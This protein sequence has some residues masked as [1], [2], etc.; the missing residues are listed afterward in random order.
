MGLCQRGI[1]YV[2]HACAFSYQSWNL[3]N[4][5]IIV[6]SSKMEATI[7][8]V[9]LMVGCST[10][11]DPNHPMCFTDK[12]ADSLPHAD[13]CKF[14]FIFPEKN[15]IIKAQLWKVSKCA[16]FHA[17]AE[18]PQ[19]HYSVFAYF[20]LA[21]FT[22]NLFLRRMTI[23]I[24]RSGFVQIGYKYLCLH[25]PMICLM[26]FEFALSMIIL[27]IRFHDTHTHTLPFKSLESPRKW[28]LR[29]TVNRKYSQ[30]IVSVRNNNF[31]LENVL[32]FFAALHIL[33]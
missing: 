33:H 3:M 21:S 18:P 12:V 6:A 25:E 16:S 26:T 8:L 20:R 31:V 2:T 4:K 32:Y 14:L 24:T 7:D 23:W 1:A 19:L 17:L 13:I 22:C 10:M 15:I 28:Q 5:M 27:F 30:D 9:P 29:F 11:C